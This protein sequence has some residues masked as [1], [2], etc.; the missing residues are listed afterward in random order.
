MPPS[1]NETLCG[2]ADALKIDGSFVRDA[3]S[4]PASLSI[5]EA[6]A[7]LAGNFGMQTIAEWAEDL[8]TLEALA[9][10]GI[11]HVQGYVVSRPIGEV[12][13]LQADSVVDLIQDPK[14]AAFV[15]TLSAMPHQG[16]PVSVEHDH[17]TWTVH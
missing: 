10:A 12:E 1:R 13:L 2:P 8:P 9:L 15:R 16:C 4:H 7:K 6:I 17:R 11:D 5:I 14:V 3:A